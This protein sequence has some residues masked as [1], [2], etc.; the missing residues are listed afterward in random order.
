MTVNVQ[1]TISTA[2]LGDLGGSIAATADAVVAAGPI[3][4]TSPATFQEVD[5]TATIAKAVLIVFRCTTAVTVLTNNSGGG[6]TTDTVVL[7]A[8]VPWVWVSGGYV[9]QPLQ[10]N[11]TKLYVSNTSGVAGTFYAY[12]LYSHV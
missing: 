2:T 7:I 9:A 1:S 5:W 8:N 11:V 3:T 12:V 4:I 10:N 6:G